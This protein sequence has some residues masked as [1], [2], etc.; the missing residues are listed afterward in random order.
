MTDD[1]FRAWLTERV[2]YYLECE[3]AD[4]DPAR[5]L[6]VDGLDSVLAL[7]LCGDIEDHLDVRLEATVVWDHPTVDALVDHLSG[8]TAAA[9]S[10]T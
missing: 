5:N 7:S 10:A 3:P 8:V 4:V 9:G 1:A 2:A 6:A